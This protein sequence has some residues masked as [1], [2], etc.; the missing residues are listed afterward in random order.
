MN[1][2]PDEYKVHL[3]DTGQTPAFEAFMGLRAAW[4]WEKDHTSAVGPAMNLHRLIREIDKPAEL[5]DQLRLS[6]EQASS[7]SVAG[8]GSPALDP[9]S[10]DITST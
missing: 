8:G 2:R 3:M 5:V 1:L 10:D 9:G 4:P 6:V 7:E